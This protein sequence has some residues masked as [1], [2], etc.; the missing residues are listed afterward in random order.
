MISEYP[1]SV[2][3]TAVCLTCR[4]KLI[5]HYN[6]WSTAITM[7]SETDRLYLKLYNKH[8][9]FQFMRSLDNNAILVKATR[10]LILD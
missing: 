5:Q 2:V 6:V 9:L 3:L 10:I 1:L 4:S 8:I 7:M